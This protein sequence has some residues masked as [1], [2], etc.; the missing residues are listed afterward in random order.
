MKKDILL[1]APYFEKI[2]TKVHDGE[3]L[4]LGQYLFNI[5]YD[6]NILEHKS[7]P[8]NT[9]IIQS[10]IV[11]VHLWKNELLLN[12]RL[13]KVLIYLDWAKSYFNIETIIGIGSIATSL[14]EE[15]FDFNSSI[16]IIIDE[17]GSH[18]RE[19]SFKADDFDFVRGYFK[20]F[21]CLTDNYLTSTNINYNPSD[22]VSLYSSR[23]CQ[24]K[25]SFCSYNNNVIGW[26]E[27]NIDDFILDIKKLNKYFFVTKYSLFDNNFG[28]NKKRNEDKARHL[29]K[30]IA[31]FD[32]KVKLSLN[33]SLDGV[34]KK[35]LDDFKK[36]SV[37]NILVGLESLN[38][39]TLS[40][41][42]N[43]PQDLDHST[44]MIEYAEKKGI[45]PIVSYILFQ[46]WL[47]LHELKYEVEK[48][49]EFGRYRII[50]FLANSKLQVIPNTDIEER[51]YKDNL[52][53]KGRLLRDYIF[54]DNMVE[55]IYKKLNAF[56]K[57]KMLNCDLS[58]T[59]L[60]KLK[61][62]EWKYLKSLLKLYT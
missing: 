58:V 60:S 35:I 38:E 5:G 20:E 8:K 42:Y 50:Q 12:Q 52:L 43:K 4:Y 28:I 36:S 11:I 24:K 13:C 26:K 55:K 47:T 32:F 34:N 17:F 27:R 37:K 29:S 53:V 40:N 59:S 30:E 9:D 51:L 61:I 15:I 54:K 48:I 23:G 49:E 46:P 1:F 33:I 41:I 39:N 18:Y 45:I 25:C 62:D 14:R 19:N 22:I 56:L 44:A 6:I 7:I 2:R 21:V 3:L 31:S 57:E 10:S 16:D